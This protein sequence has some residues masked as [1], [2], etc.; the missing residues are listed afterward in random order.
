MERHD[1]LSN[2]PHTESFATLTELL[3]ILICQCV[4]H[5]ANDVIPSLRHTSV[6]RKNSYSEYFQNTNSECIL[7]MNMNMNSNILNLF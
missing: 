6:V 4:T 1:R 2:M 5:D 3:D 7:S